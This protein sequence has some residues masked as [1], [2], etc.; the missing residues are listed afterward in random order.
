MSTDIL[1]ECTLGKRLGSLG[2]NKKYK[3]CLQEF[4]YISG[5]VFN[6]MAFWILVSCYHLKSTGI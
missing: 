6:V 3:P 4:S 2:L 1:L 5:L